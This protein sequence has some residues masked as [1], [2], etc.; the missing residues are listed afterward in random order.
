MFKIPEFKTDKELFDFLVEKESDIFY[1]KKSALKYADSFTG[2]IQTLKDFGIASKSN[3][4]DSN[5]LKVKAVINTTNLLDSHGDVHIKGLWDKSLSENKRIKHLQ[6]HKMAFDKVISDGDSLKAYAK[7]YNWK[8]LGYDVEGKT[9]ALVFESIVK[10]ERN[11]F[12]FNEYKE[13][14][15]DNHSVG[16]RYVKMITCINDEDYGAKYE[17]WQKYSKFVVN[18]VDLEKRRYFWAVTEAKAIE[19]SAVVLGS[20]Q[21][22]PT[23]SI[24]ENKTIKNKRVSPVKSWLEI[25]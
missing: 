6:E 21:I 22:T 5:E 11:A 10:R 13:G 25:N 23:I 15:V 18:K 16:M 14:R 8:E 3:L 19:G 4:A 1:V 9:Q 2:G 24:S 12:M 7:E 17:A 20:N